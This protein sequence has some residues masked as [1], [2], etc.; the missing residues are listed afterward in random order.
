MK[1][2]LIIF[3]SALCILSLEIEAQAIADHPISGT[4]FLAGEKYLEFDDILYI[5]GFIAP[6]SRINRYKTFKILYKN[7]IRVISLSAIRYIR[8]D[9]FQSGLGQKGEQVIK[10]LS[11]KVETKTRTV[12]EMPYYELNW[13]LV[14]TYDSKSGL[15]V[16]RKIPFHKDGKLNIQKIVFD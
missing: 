5:H 7:K 8:I 6:T 15:I 10:N 14:M 12:F 13:A 11:L 9:K 1:A 3:T 4:I 2:C 16:E